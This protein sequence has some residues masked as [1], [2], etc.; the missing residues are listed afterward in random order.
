MS[1]LRAIQRGNRRRRANARRFERNTRVEERGRFSMEALEPRILLSAA[2]FDS[3]DLGVI[4]SAITAYKTDLNSQVASAG[5]AFSDSGLGTAVDGILASELSNFNADLVTF[6][7]NV[8]AAGSWSDLDTADSTL[9][10]IDLV[11]DAATGAITLQFMSSTFELSNSVQS[12]LDQIAATTSEINA[13]SSPSPAAPNGS[14]GINCVYDYEAQW[15]L[16]S[17][18][19]VTGEG[20]WSNVSVEAGIKGSTTPTSTDATPTHL[21]FVETSAVSAAAY[22]LSASQYIYTSDDV[23]NIPG[24]IVAPTNPVAVSW[25]ASYTD[26]G[27]SSTN[28]SDTSVVTVSSALSSSGPTAAVNESGPAEFDSAAFLINFRSNFRDFMDVIDSV[29]IELFTDDSVS[30]PEDVD[31]LTLLGLDGL[32]AQVE[33]ISADLSDLYGLEDTLE[34][35]LNGFLP[36]LEDGT[37]TIGSF[38]VTLEYV[39]PVPGN[40]VTEAFNVGLA[41]DV[42]VQNHNSASTTDYLNSAAGISATQLGGSTDLGTF[43]DISTVLNHVEIL[44]EASLTASIQFAVDLGDDPATFGQVSMLAHVP[45][46]EDP[47]TPAGGTYFEVTAKG[48]VVFSDAEISLSVGTTDGFQLGAFAKDGYASFGSTGLIDATGL[49][50]DFSPGEAGANS[51]AFLGQL[52]PATFLIPLDSDVVLNDGT[53]TLTISPVVTLG[54]AVVLPAY[55]PVDTLPLGGFDS[56]GDLTLQT[57]DGMGEQ[58][59][60]TDDDGNII[61]LPAHPVNSIVGSLSYTYAAG[62]GTFSAN[63]YVPDVSAT[64][65]LNSPAA[66]K[67][68][69]DSII[70][71]IGDADLLS[72]VSSVPG[73]GSPIAQVLTTIQEKL[74]NVSALV[75]NATTQSNANPNP[76]TTNLEIIQWCLFELFKK[77]DGTSYLLQSAGG[78]AV[79]EWWEVPF[80]SDIDKDV[81]VNNNGDTANMMWARLEVHL[82]RTI[83]VSG[84]VD[85]QDL[86]TSGAGIG[87]LEINFE[88]TMNASVTATLSASTGVY[89]QAWYGLPATLDLVGIDTDSKITLLA[90]DDG[91]GSTTGVNEFEAAFSVEITTPNSLKMLFGGTGFG[92]S[93][94]LSTFTINTTLGFDIGDEDIVVM[95]SGVTP[96][97]QFNNWSI[98]GSF[99][100]DVNPVLSLGGVTAS[101]GENA[102]AS[103]L[104]KIDFYMYMGFRSTVEKAAGAPLTT[105]WGAQFDIAETYLDTGSFIKQFIAPIADPIFDMLEPVRPVIEILT[106]EIDL[107]SQLAPSLDADSDTK[108]TLIE[109]MSAAGGASTKVAKVTDAL[110]GIVSLFNILDSIPRDGSTYSIPLGITATKTFGSWVELSAITPPPPTLAMMPG[111]PGSNGGGSGS[112]KA[113]RFMQKLSDSTD[114]LGDLLSDGST[115]IDWLTVDFLA[116][117]QFDDNLLY[118]L[119]FGDGTLIPDP[120]TGA[121]DIY[122]IVTIDIP[123]INFT[124]GLNVKFPIFSFASLTLGG[125]VSFGFDYAIKYD[126][127]GISKFMDTISATPAENT[128][129]DGITGGWETQK[130]LYLAEGLLIGEQTPITL[131]ANVYATLAAGISGIIEVGVTGG[132][133]ADVAFTM[134]LWNDSPIQAAMQRPTYEIGVGYDTDDAHVENLNGVPTFYC[135]LSDWNYMA[136]FDIQGGLSFY[137]DVFLWIGLDLGWFGKITLV[138]ETWRLVEVE[139]LSFD[140]QAPDQ[141]RPAY[142]APVV[143][144]AID[145]NSTPLTLVS[146][147]TPSEVT[148]QNYDTYFIFADEAG[149]VRVTTATQTAG[150]LGES[151]LIPDSAKIVFTDATNGSST[152]KPVKIYVEAD[153]T[154]DLDFS[155]T[156]GGDAVYYEGT[157]RTTLVGNAGNDTLY[158]GSG[159]DSIDGGLGDDLID[160]DMGARVYDA[161]ALANSLYGGSGADTIYGSV[162]AD[163]IYSGGGGS[164]ASDA[165]SVDYLYGYRA[166]LESEGSY[167][168]VFGGDVFYASTEAGRVVIEGT[169]GA[170]TVNAD[171]NYAHRVSTFGGADS[172]TTGG[173]ADIIN[174]GSDNDTVISNAGNDIIEAGSGNDSVTSGAGNDSVS[175]GYGSDFVDGGADHDFINAS[176]VLP[177]SAAGQTAHYDRTDINDIRGGTG[178]DS[179]YGGSHGGTGAG[180]S[181]DGG[182]GEDWLDG[183]KGM[184]TLVGG[185]GPDTLD[186]GPGVDQ[187]YGDSATL[188]AGRGND[189][190]NYT[191]G[192]DGADTII[193][194]GGTI[195]DYVEG[196]ADSLGDAIFIKASDFKARSDSI[197]AASAGGSYDATLYGANA[198]VV[199]VAPVVATPSEVVV[200][201]NSLDVTI[202]GIEVLDITSDAYYLPESYSQP[203][204]TNGNG[205]IDSDDDYLVQ[206]YYADATA[207]ADSFIFGDLSNTSLREINVDLGACLDLADAVTSIPIN[208]DPNPQ[209]GSPA[210]NQRRFEYDPTTRYLTAQ[211]YNGSGWVS[212]DTA[213]AGYVDGSYDPENDALSTAFTSDAIDR[214]EILV[215]S[216]DSFSNGLNNDD[217][218]IAKGFY[219]L[220]QKVSNSQIEVSGV[221]DLAGDPVGS[222]AYVETATLQGKNYSAYADGQADI[223]GKLPALSDA[224]ALA[225]ADV[226]ADQVIIEGTSSVDKFVVGTTSVEADSANQV[227]GVR[228]VFVNRLDISDSSLFPKFKISGASVLDTL[229]VDGGDETIEVDGRIEGDTISAEGVGGFGVS[230]EPFISISLV[231]GAGDDR[232]IGSDFNDTIRGGAGYD[233][234]TGGLGTDVFE[235]DLFDPDDPSAG[236]LS[237]GLYQDELVEE[238][239]ANFSV[240]PD[241]TGKFDLVIDHQGMDGLGSVPAQAPALRTAMSGDFPQTLG[242]GGSAAS[243][244]GFT[245]VGVPIDTRL[246]TTDK[247]EADGTTPLACWDQYT[248]TVR[249]IDAAGDLQVMT[250]FQLTGEPV[251]HPD[252]TSLYTLSSLTYNG[253]P[254]SEATWAYDSI[255]S[256]ASVE[257]LDNRL[258]DNQVDVPADREVEEFYDGLFGNLN[259]RAPDTGTFVNTF[260]VEK[261]KGD[262]TDPLTGH[263]ILDGALGSD[264]YHVTVWNKGAFVR[265]TD[266]SVTGSDS[267]YLFAYVLG[268]TVS[269]QDTSRVLVSAVYGDGSETVVAEDSLPTSGS[270]HVTQDDTYEISA[271]YSFIEHTGVQKVALRA[272]LGSDYFSVSDVGCGYEI[273]GQGGEDNFDIGQVA[274]GESSSFIKWP[275]SLVSTGDTNGDGS[276][277]ASDE[278]SYVASLASNIS[279]TQVLNSLDLA[280]GSLTSAEVLEIQE[281]LANYPGADSAV[282]D[283]TGTGGTKTFFVE[284]KR[285]GQTF[286]EVMSF[287]GIT[288][289]GG[290]IRLEGVTR[291]ANY[292]LPFDFDAATAVVTFLWFDHE[293]TVLGDY[294]SGVLIQ[295]LTNGASYVSSFFGGD[296]EDT[297]QVYRNKVEIYLYGEDGNDIFAVFANLEFDKTQNIYDGVGLTNVRYTFNA[298]VNINGGAGYDRLT[299]VGTGIADEFIVTTELVWVVDPVTNTDTTTPVIDSATGQQ[300]LRQVVLGAGVQPNAESVESIALFGGDGADKFYVYGIAPGVDFTIDGGAGSDQIYIGYGDKELSGIFEGYQLQAKPFMVTPAPRII[301]WEEEYVQ[302]PDFY[303]PT[304]EDPT[305]WTTPPQHVVLVPVYDNPAP[306]PV[307]PPLVEGGGGNYSTQLVSENKDL[308][309]IVQGHLTVNGGS[310][311]GTDLLRLD[312]SG[313]SL[314]GSAYVNA[315]GSKADA[316]YIYGD[317]VVGF[318]MSPLLDPDHPDYGSILPAINLG[319]GEDGVQAF[320][321]VEVILPAIGGQTLVVDTARSFYGDGVSNN[322]SVNSDLPVTVI[323][324]DYGDDVQVK[325]LRG[326]VT[327]DLSAGASGAA[328]DRVFIGYDPSNPYDVNGATFGMAANSQLGELTGLLTISGPSASDGSALAITVSDTLNDG[329]QHSRLDWDLTLSG[330]NT[331]LSGT[332]LDLVFSGADS[333]DLT[334]GSSSDWVFV[335][336]ALNT[337]RVNTGYGNDVISVSSVAN[338]ANA[339][340]LSE[341]ADSLN[342]DLE[343]TPPVIPNLD[344]VGSGLLFVDPGEDVNSLFVSD[345]G[346]AVNTDVELGYEENSDYKRMR[347]TKSVGSGSLFYK[348]IDSNV[349]NANNEDHI[350]G[351]NVVFSA[352]SAADVGRIHTYPHLLSHEILRLGD[353][354]DTYSAPGGAAGSQEYGYLVID[355]QDG[356]DSLDA[357]DHSVPVRLFGGSVPAGSG[358]TSNDSLYGTAFDDHVY[359]GVG[360]DLIRSSGGD[361]LI[362]GDSPP[363]ALVMK[364]CPI[365]C[366]PFTIG[367]TSH[368]MRRLSWAKTRS[369]TSSESSPQWSAVRA[370]P[371]QLNANQTRKP[372]TEKS[373]FR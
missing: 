137:L 307:H 72:T 190:F 348:S 370:K 136:P 179:L 228:D 110:N 106:T 142:V 215:D 120:V 47:A 331:R 93:V 325:T 105:N 258:G 64:S 41:F 139:L 159:G 272:G 130:I 4:A 301:D 269:S 37:T 354:D 94:D 308:A 95:T 311:V 15:V 302:G 30:P 32:V 163:V 292:S 270:M 229:T 143:A 227:T 317:S 278:T 236:Y 31:V 164:P 202:K 255:P 61:T 71:G 161:A 226:F 291:E 113:E 303:D 296:G 157:G 91:L 372:G 189:T 369:I 70:A 222:V 52:S 28:T 243:T 68:A 42:A 14:I 268:D 295:D 283:G 97:G 178:N 368:K 173:G 8:L 85:L 322:L 239:Q 87:G 212:D 249:Y 49:T 69:L 261:W 324:S 194:G 273:Y 81:V 233:T 6:K 361:D 55:F 22:S 339:A 344:D 333:L 356:H 209:A 314:T 320:N 224:F 147:A 276:I 57:R 48:I 310:G 138:D 241:G 364:A 216:A 123:A 168:G 67:F 265:V 252:E 38:D 247:F 39:A 170:D 256:G 74:T 84:N 204:D 188:S 309:D 9:D 257:F 352:G 220:V 334:L 271:G 89:V 133:Q 144:D 197:Q 99:D 328:S 33:A 167:G 238:R 225:S 318:G 207:A 210:L 166:P 244:P 121:F 367:K 156:S 315:S 245:V 363:K 180:D 141:D 80:D 219:S 145:T 20:S 43:G 323:G 240:T 282:I 135:R 158:G 90:A 109:A 284:V 11:A 262:P 347:W 65:Y 259:L 132:I 185:D 78:P 45:A 53:P 373:G 187:M 134:N 111:G 54:A 319:T 29:N 116:V 217:G 10:G 1:V 60:A 63:Y 277:D 46:V 50:Q 66:L 150:T 92:A 321:S 288:D 191:A 13:V 253:D 329:S 221:V 7:A 235:R 171:T 107:L 100:F 200:T 290:V 35:T 231:G 186:G 251:Q 211:F 285:P 155:G 16:V 5:G 232:I 44:F 146:G 275:L 18:T 117:G 237:Q 114:G 183:R 346:S 26:S 330:L 294:V 223:N 19:G 201:V 281:M 359:G 129:W 213:F 122:D 25:T 131:S 17:G 208:A 286:G 357:T 103:L 2:P 27:Y 360:D 248:I 172:I 88:G 119:L 128:P 205:S 36:F 83:T 358:G 312:N 193:D 151:W 371:T 82:E 79:T 77:D 280:A 3:D 73:I 341:L 246:E 160:A 162:N 234:I 287:T 153:V 242:V 365:S 140:Y 86:I 104:P 335:Q 181:L 184:D 230:D 59:D 40:S 351:G 76:A 34:S 362:Y 342:P 203:N 195:A 177:S 56:L 152:G 154:N 299:I 214:I 174:A 149:F 198:L 126:T 289:V 196:A 51:S 327:L 316:G 75:T 313:S 264:D 263:V 250:G 124:G 118:S 115:P 125:S 336:G 165:T 355:G 266:S 349:S 293:A 305:R 112:S 148:L 326:D 206:A 298:P 169:D 267:N 127:Y 199:N 218:A 306:Y 102:A 12:V 176:A 98:N 345:A 182:D 192:A 24:A 58:V 304:Y 108:V 175:A 260:H 338:S 23:S 332:L 274:A 96:P 254:V 297:F 350:W 353:G 62:G 366:K 300:K 279:A 343:A 21:G 337:T 340:D 101:S